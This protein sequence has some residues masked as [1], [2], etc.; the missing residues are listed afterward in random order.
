MTISISIIIPTLNE[1]KNILNLLRSIKIQEL[2]EKHYLCEVIVVDNGSSDK[3]IINAKSEGAKTYSKPELSIAGLRN[4]GAKNSSGELLVFLDADNILTRNA[5][6]NLVKK[7]NNEKI[8]ALC[9]HLRPLN[10]ATWVEK[11]WYYHLKPINMELFKLDFLYSGAF[12]IRRDVFFKIGQFN[13]NLR[14]GEDS[15]LSVKLKN[16]DYEIFVVTESV[17]YN[18]GYP[19][20]LIQFFKDE[21]WH[22][23][24]LKTIF[25]HKQLDYLT[26]F[27]FL[28]FS[29][30]LVSLL[31]MLMFIPPSFFIVPIVFILFSIASLSEFL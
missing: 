23:D 13:E 28:C 20:N 2:D 26:G 4:F 29:F 14:I 6:N 25:I 30:F 27:L 9:A 8:G 17:I 10:N 15:E 3:T 12:V 7:I 5:L 11:A 19:K 21:L 16:K 1:E 24:S 31:S 18:T 22:G